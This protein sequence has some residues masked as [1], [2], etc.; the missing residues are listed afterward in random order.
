[1]E[2]N[3]YAQLGYLNRTEYSSLQSAMHGQ[4]CQRLDSVTC[5]NSRMALAAN[6]AGAQALASHL[7]AVPAPA[8]AA[9]VH[10]P[11]IVT[12]P[13]PPPQLYNAPPATQTATATGGR[14]L[15]S[16]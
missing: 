9:S 7:P 12:P 14:K 16:L 13:P 5:Y 15:L 1:M 3:E 6:N 4:F 8:P 2:D 10:P 11:A